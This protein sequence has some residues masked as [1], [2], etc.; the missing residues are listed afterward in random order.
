MFGGSSSLRRNRLLSAS[1]Y[2]GVASSR[3]SN[4][5]ASNA[6]R[7]GIE[8]KLSNA[9]T[10][11]SSKSTTPTS[12]DGMSSTAR[13]ILD[14]LERMSTPIRD[15]Q[16]I[17]IVGRA[18]KRRQVMSELESSL[19]S[20]SHASPS[21]SK[22]RRPNLGGQ[23]T[24]LSNHRTLLNGPPMRTLMSPTTATSATTTPRSR[25]NAVKSARMSTTIS[26]L[27]VSSAQATS[28]PFSN[29]GAFSSRTSDTTFKPHHQN[30]N[31]SHSGSKYTI[32]FSVPALTGGLA[33]SSSKKEPAKPSFSVSPSFMTDTKKN[34]LTGKVRTKLG[35]KAVD[36]QD[37]ETAEL[38]AHLQNP[39]SSG[40]D[41]KQ[42]PSF[43][44]DF[45]KGSNKK[46]DGKVTSTTSSGSLVNSCSSSSSGT[47]QKPRAYLKPFYK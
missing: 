43:G 40:L 18:E 19:V 37:Q 7:S 46:G 17:P 15:A 3:Y 32:P 13:L 9:P 26:P 34:S 5:H 1:P 30:S 25:L 45:L 14:T 35:D 12:D 27:S 20:S 10:P 4:R 41:I 11:S 29:A 38:P 24:S 8:P 39:I 31:E 22:R 23:S 44:L 36:L 6:S 21:N 47:L 33:S 28:T 42:L 16:K 2:Q